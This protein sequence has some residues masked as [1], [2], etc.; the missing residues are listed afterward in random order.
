MSDLDG[1]YYCVQK[2]LSKRTNEDNEVEYLI[3]WEGYPSTKSTWEPEENILCPDLL[4]NFERQWS[5]QNEPP[6][7]KRAK[8]T[9]SPKTTRTTRATIE[10][11]SND[12]EIESHTY[13]LVPNVKAG[14]Q[15]NNEAEELLG[16]K[17]FV[18]KGKKQLMFFVKWK[19]ID[20]CTFVPT[21]EANERVPKMVIDFYESRICFTNTN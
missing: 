6:P 16:L 12:Q 7:S 9:S 8:T 21:Y 14:W 20:V 15:Y 2:I 18:V 3:K 4:E 11:E 17:E 10:P 1:E 19:G 5:T 13:N